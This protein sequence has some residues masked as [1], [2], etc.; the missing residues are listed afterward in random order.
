MNTR[1]KLSYKALH[2]EPE[3][4]LELPVQFQLRTP[5]TKTLDPL[6]KVA[7]RLQTASNM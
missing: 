3:A 4:E 2:K 5:S 1:P 6:K 7:K